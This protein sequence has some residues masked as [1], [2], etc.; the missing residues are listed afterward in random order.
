[1]GYE[2]R[3]TREV[4]LTLHRARVF[5]SCGVDPRSELPAVERVNGALLQRYRPLPST[6]WDARMPL[7]T[8]SPPVRNPTEARSTSDPDPIDRRPECNHGTITF[9]LGLGCGR[10]S[11]VFGLSCERF[12]D[13]SALR[14]Q[15]ISNVLRM[16]T[17]WVAIVCPMCLRPQA[18]RSRSPRPGSAQT[19]DGLKVYPDSFL[20]QKR[21]NKS[22][23]TGSMSFP[24]RLT[25]S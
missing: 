19:M 7:V 24:L 25:F 22:Q 4:R 2:P 21:T 9:G 3:R 12:A 18:E 23:N 6:T 13:A 5:G 17:G 8:Q 1:M 15:R 20:Q 16:L 11:I 10:V 14:R